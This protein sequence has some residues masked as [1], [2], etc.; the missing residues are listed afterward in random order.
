MTLYF[1][2]TSALVKRYIVEDGT[3]WV[4]S[5]LA[6]N[7]GN[8]SF[9]SEIARVEANSSIA[10]QQREGRF[11][12]V[13]VNGFRK[14]ITRHFGRDYIVLNV[15][16]AITQLAIDLLYRHSI[17]AY[18]AVQLATAL[19][20]HQRTTPLHMT[21]IFVC[22]DTRLLAIAQLEGLAIDDPNQHG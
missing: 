6:S 20:L 21:P 1:L 7:S 11:N 2:D 19:T 9:V 16:S 4:R 3:V 22:A 13:Q 5:I 14:L 12:A 18:D 10:R 8:R 15:N 17:R